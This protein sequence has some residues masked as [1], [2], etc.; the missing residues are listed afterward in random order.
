MQIESKSFVLF[1]L[2]A[3]AVAVEQ[4]NVHM[5]I[6]N[7]DSFAPVCDI[8]CELRIRSEYVQSHKKKDRRSSARAHTAVTGTQTRM[9]TI[10]YSN[11]Q[12]TIEC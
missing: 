5:Q 6:N 3:V 9:T 4:I 8:R 2:V 11:K 10:E 7:G 12:K 1:F